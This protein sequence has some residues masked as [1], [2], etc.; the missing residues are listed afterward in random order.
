MHT[1]LLAASLLSLGAPRPAALEAQVP[2]ASRPALQAGLAAWRHAVAAGAITRTDVL[3][4][5]DYSRPSTEPRLFVID[6]PGNKVT[7]TELVAHGRGSGENATLRFSNAAGSLMTSLGVFRAAG[8]YQGQHGL[9]LRL[10]GLEAGFNDRAR[11]RA[12]VMHAAAYVNS[13]IIAAQGRLG[14]SWG[15]PAVRPEIAKKLIET[16]RDGSL[17]VAYYPDAN[18]L[19]RSEFLKPEASPVRTSPADPS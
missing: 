9:S 1:L 6:V 3:T 16:I 17:V 13:Q 2:A 15:C 12:I 14:R 10:D 19:A 7:F 11:E 8:T 18:W 5:I 4:V